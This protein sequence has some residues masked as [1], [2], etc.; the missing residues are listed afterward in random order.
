MRRRIT[1]RSFGRIVGSVVLGGKGLVTGAVGFR[2]DGGNSAA[3]GPRVVI[4]LDGT[5]WKLAGLEVG[6][7]EKLG[8]YGGASEKVSFIATSVPN[9]VQLAINLEDPYGQGAEIAQ[10]NRR[11]WW[12]VRAFPS[13]HLHGNQQA[14]LLFEGVDYFA[15][16]WL[17][18]EKLGT[19]EGTYTRFSY[20]ITRR[21][22]L[23]GDNYL[24]VRVTSPWKVPGR[25]HYEFMKGEFDEVYQDMPGPGQVVFPLG[26]HRSV[27]VEVTDRSRLE[28]INIWTKKLEDRQARLGVRAVVSNQGVARELKL[29]LTIEPEN[30]SGPSLRIAPTA[31][32]FSGA[33]GEQRVV[34]LDV[35][36]SDPKPWWTW[37]QGGQNL[38]RATANLTDTQ[39]KVI[40]SL[41]TI[42]GI[43]TI[44]RDSSLTYKLNGRP[45]FLRGAWYPMARLYPADTDR[46]TYEKDLR[47]ARH[48]NMNHIVNY[49]VVE[50]EDFY[51]LADRLGILLFVELPFN[52]Q[53]PIDALNARYPRRD[54]FIRWASQEVGQ[55]VRALGNHPSIG[56]WSPVSE[57]TDNGSDFTTSADPRIGA[58]ADGYAIFLDKM[59]GVVTAN[60]PDSLYFRSYCDFGE[61]HFWEGSLFRNT[62]YDQH[63]DA[64]AQFVSEYGAMAFFP[65]QSIR[66][67]VDPDKFWG[68]KHGRWSNLNLPVDVKKLSY[69]VE[70]QYDGLD[71]VTTFIVDHV[72]RHPQTLWDY[73][74]DSQTYQAFLYGYAGDAYRR[75][76]FAPIS[77][78][79]S[80]NFKS[81][82]EKPI[83][84]FGVIDCFES[85]LPAYYAQKRT[86]AP[87][88]MS[89]AV[90]YA[91]E[92]A[93]AG[94]DWEAPVWLSNATETDLSASLECALYNLKGE[95]LRQSRKQASVPANRAQEVCKLSWRLPE[96]PGVYLL[97]GKASGA[98]GELASAEMYVRVAPRATRKALRVLVVGTRD[99]AQPV[100]D[101]LN[102]LG[103]VATLV[104]YEATVI[105]LQ[106]FPFPDSAESLLQ[107]YDAIWLAGFNNYWREAPEG[108]TQVMLK[109][110]EAGATFIHSGSWGSFHGGGDRTAGLDLT[111]LEQILPVNLKHENDVFTTHTF[112]VDIPSEPAPSAA[113]ATLKVSPA[114]PVWMKEINFEG[115]ALESY[116]V[117]EPRPEATVLLEMNGHPLLVSGRYGKGQTFAYLGF[118]PTGGGNFR[119]RYL[120]SAT[121]ESESLQDRRSVIV[122][123]AIRFSAEGRLFTIISASL[124][125]LA[126]GE[127]PPSRLSDLVEERATPLF[128]TLKNLPQ[129][130]WPQVSLAWT[131]S[132]EG[133]L[134]ARIHIQNGPTYL[135][136]L[137]L[138][139]EGPD[140]REGNALA[141]WSNQFF[142]LLPGEDV[143]CAVEFITAG[144]RPLRQVTLEAETRYSPESKSYL[145]PEPPQ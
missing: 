101:Y 37:D 126:T 48:A 120:G 1:R 49:T 109:A 78:M 128:E 110:V 10:I 116:H 39:G 64:R 38:Y 47:L 104:V 144:G 56:V 135:R 87:V 7:G 92:S 105:P 93:P 125:A 9:D 100:A 18:G 117:L 84:G 28:E 88:S 97:R 8:I 112:R 55:I 129:A 44:E 29:R 11:E 80:W 89:F 20:D 81:F 82:P 13:P 52:Q 103:A 51:D 106:G 124:L 50:K 133:H 83:C 32:S 33:P 62:T 137:R 34:A 140:F 31:V 131:R 102:N 143:D 107:N 24:A 53:G 63:F 16:V 142:D 14:R 70:Y 35:E 90:R 98:D 5:G 12:Y 45:L 91:L 68:D 25:S 30:F 59:N 21:L 79:R 22:R 114:A 121:V 113:E 4:P 111:P 75:K 77:G 41:S 66:R 76:L 67:I 54:E 134:G 94:S 15:D 122:D 58:A 136:G 72:N 141:L 6:E 42:F 119:D 36:V 115:C 19:H 71:F 27:R 69:L 40:D 57:V 99:W 123:R 17:N 132:P 2:G 23:E 43:R 96:E 108:W 26:L 74:N 73:V 65:L 139:F 95:R 85:P 60:D 130:P 118:S 145:I 3:T 46:W 86:Y 127:N 61:H 138:R